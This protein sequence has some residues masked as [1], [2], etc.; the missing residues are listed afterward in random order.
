MREDPATAERTVE[1]LAALLRY[2]LDTGARP[3]VPLRQELCIVR[4]YLEIEKTRF[5][6][7]LRCRIEVAPEL[8]DLEVPPMSLQLLVENS[9]KHAVSVNRQGGEVLVTARLEDG[10]LVLAVSDDGPGFDLRAIHP[11]HGLENLQERLAALFGGQGGIAL[12]Q[13]GERM[14]VEI[15]VPRGSVLV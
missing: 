11:G 2:S 15:R 12:S 8:E 9:I 3:L 6:G 5:A 4:D 13:R 14:V 7:R 1:R 10:Q